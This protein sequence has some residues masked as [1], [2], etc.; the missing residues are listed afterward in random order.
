MRDNQIISVASM[1]HFQ[2]MSHFLYWN[3]GSNGRK[4][5]VVYERSS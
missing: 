4:I 3:K 2:A 5:E 1:S